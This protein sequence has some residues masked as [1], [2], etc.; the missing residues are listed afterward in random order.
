MRR[1]KTINIK[2]QDGYIVIVTIALLATLL[3]VTIGSFERLKNNR[4]LSGYNRDSAESLLLAESA[5][6]FMIGLYQ[7]TSMDGDAFIDGNEVI[8]INLL[9]ISDN[10]PT[11][12]FYF[13]SNAGGTIDQNTP[14]ILQR[15]ANGEAMNL[16]NPLANRVVPF[17]SNN[18]LISDLFVDA[19]TRPMV[20]TLNGV[21]LF[22]IEAINTSGEWDAA[23]TIAANP[24]IAAAWMEIVD[25]PNI[26]GSLEVYIAALA[27]VGRSKSY[28]QKLYGTVNTNLGPGVPEIVQ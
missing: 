27:K 20:F 6:N 22:Q 8:N 28:V 17:A 21:N 19:N 11:P 9:P 25:D 13:V 12:Y 16:S 26:I 3:S 24:K 23:A 7:T 18:L 14:S 10:L 2:K 4:Q 5:M 1:R 15:V